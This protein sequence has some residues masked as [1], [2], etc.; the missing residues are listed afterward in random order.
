VTAYPAGNIEDGVISFDWTLSSPLSSLWRALTDNE[1]LS[2]WLAPHVTLEL[3]L[4]GRVVID[5]GSDGS[6]EGEV[7]QLKPE[8]LL[9]YTWGGSQWPETSTV[10]WE[11]Q[12]R[13]Q[14]ARLL[15]THQ[16]LAVGT[17]DKRIKELAAGW[18][19]FLDS[20][21]AELGEKP[22]PDRYEE[23]LKEYTAR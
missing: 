16:G 18:H 3:R 23:L 6:A 2:R 20:L 7:T 12:P 8:Y 4:G 19:D 1:A 17:D 22:N 10:R 14:D 5:W 15:L 9:E 21:L 11:I 13:G